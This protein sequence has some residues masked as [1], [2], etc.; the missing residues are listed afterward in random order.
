[1]RTI[2]INISLTDGDIDEFPN[3]DNVGLVE[4]LNNRVMITLSRNAMI[5]LGKQLIKLAYTNFQDGYHVHVDPCEEGY[6]SQPMG[7]Y[8]HPKSAEIIICCSEFE[9]IDKCMK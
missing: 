9:S 3:K 8:S 6:T 5:G 4:V 1:M 2:D 7:F